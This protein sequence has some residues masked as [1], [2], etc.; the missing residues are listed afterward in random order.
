MENQ[1]SFNSFFTQLTSTEFIE[2][3]AVS[4]GQD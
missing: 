3:P 4:P 2:G 1:S